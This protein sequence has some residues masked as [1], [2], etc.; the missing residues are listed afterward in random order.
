M[1]P[2][3]T[4]PRLG[5]RLGSRIRLQLSDKAP[6]AT[7]VF[8]APIATSVSKAP[9]ATSVY[10]APFTPSKAA[11][12][13]TSIGKNAWSPSD[14]TPPTPTTPSV[15]ALVARLARPPTPTRLVFGAPPKWTPPSEEEINTFIKNLTE[16]PKISAPRRF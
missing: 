1:L 8:K 5:P 15:T 4:G 13:N 7:S 6:I 12:I 3:P 9:I 11:P 10:D 14:M 2:P 16:P